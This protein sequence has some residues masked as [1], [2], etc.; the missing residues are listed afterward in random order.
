MA[1][2]DNS[3][4]LMRSKIFRAAKRIAALLRPDDFG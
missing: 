1:F 4:F 2:A 3:R